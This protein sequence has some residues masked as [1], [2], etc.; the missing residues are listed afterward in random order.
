VHHAEQDRLDSLASY[1]VLDTPPEAAYDS[2]TALAAQVCDAPIATVA[3]LDRDRVWCKSTFGTD[4]VEAARELSFCVDAVTD[5]STLI[6]PD[7]TRDARYQDYPNVTVAGGARAYA[8]VPL[9]GRDGLPLGTLCVVDVRT[10]RFTAAQIRTLT[11]L[12]AQVVALLEQRRRDATDG[13]SSDVL[14]QA[15]DPARLRRALDD[16]E[17]I[18]HYQPMVDL[19]SGV[20][21]G[22]E[23]LL[24]W[25][26]PALGTLTPAAF[27][28]AIE[29]SALIVPVGRA[30][31]DAASARLRRSGS[32]RCLCPV[33]WRSTWRAVS[34]PARA[35]LAMSSPRSTGITSSPASWP[36]RSPRP[37]HCRTPPSPWPSSPSSVRPVSTWP[38]TTSASAGRTSSGC[39]PCPW[40]PP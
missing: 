37:P 31:L 15:R 1:A 38:S 7:T 13:L 24:R 5:C 19:S 35:L 25:E 30:M 16:G 40:S 22:M 29:S 23:A 21:Y 32:A 17:L 26:H 3:F 27:L 9:V 33:A 36:L 4:V 10:R 2:L 8:G 12:A 11:G 14:G 20:G 28:A 39:S 18:A 34:L 6:V